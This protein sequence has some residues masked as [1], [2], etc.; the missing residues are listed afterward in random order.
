MRIACWI[1][2]AAHS[3]SCNTFFFFSTK[4]VELNSYVYAYNV[5]L[6]IVHRQFTYVAAGRL[7]YNLAGCGL[8][9]HNLVISLSQIARIEWCTSPPI[10]T[11]IGFVWLLYF[12][13]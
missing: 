8:E 11:L 7:I 12:S 5:R 9:S 13:F 1:S 10:P 6:V 4:V 3:Q 2:K